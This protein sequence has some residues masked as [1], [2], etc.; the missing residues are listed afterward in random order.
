MVRMAT[1]DD[2]K[3]WLITAGLY[4]RLRIARNEL[5]PLAK[6][7]QVSWK[8]DCYCPACK[9][10]STFTAQISSR[11]KPVPTSL[12]SQSA[13]TPIWEQAQDYLRN[14]SGNLT[15][16]CARDW[17]HT[18]DFWLRV[19]PDGDGLV[20]QKAGQFPSQHDLAGG[21]L[22]RYQELM[23][24][25]D[26]REMQCASICHGVGYHIAAFTYL[27]R[28]F[29]RRLDAAHAIAAKDSGWD[30]EKYRKEYFMDRRIELLKARLPEFLVKNQSLYGILSRGIHELDEA[31]CADG[32]EACRLGV[33]MILEQELESRRKAELQSNATTALERL[34]NKLSGPAGK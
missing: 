10:T 19:V 14:S 18:L 29:E 31:T 1:L 2:I 8:L 21:D 28:V 20:M 32:Y 11:Y 17:N 33:Q 26:I 13:G 16:R 6:Q 22:S 4:Q 9:E 24:E 15:L 5:D 7:Y 12:N 25:T 30:E 3:K 34:R 27:R 23:D